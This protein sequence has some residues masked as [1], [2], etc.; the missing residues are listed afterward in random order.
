M[1]YNNEWLLARYEA[2]ERLK[3]VFFWKPLVAPN[4]QITASCLGQ[5]WKSNFTVDG[6]TYK[7]AEHWMMAGKARLFNDPVT[8]EKILQATAPAEVKKLGQQVKN[9]DQPTWNAHKFDIVVT[10]NYHKFSQD[11]ALKKF[12]LNTQERILVEAS[13]MDR[14]WGI[15]MAETHEHAENPSLWRGE[16]LLGY[17][18]M[19][20]RDQLK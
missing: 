11:P 16:N 1:Q 2:K 6:I 8:L 10:G 13:P 9:F 15:G 7:T 17:A 20:V 19:T 5:W 12:L 4:G 14:I 3:F 18:L